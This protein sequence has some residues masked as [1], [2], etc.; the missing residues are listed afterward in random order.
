VVTGLCGVTPPKGHAWVVSLD[1][2]PRKNVGAVTITKDALMEWKI[3][4][5]EAP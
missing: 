4:K 5:A 1:G 2:E 3:D